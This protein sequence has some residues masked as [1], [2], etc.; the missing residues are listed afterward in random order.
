MSDEV[1]SLNKAKS[2][3]KSGNILEAIKIYQKF[4]IW[5]IKKIQKFFSSW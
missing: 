1:E 3:H 2:K 5:K 4:N